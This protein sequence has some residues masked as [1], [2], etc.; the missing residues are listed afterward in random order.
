MKVLADRFTYKNRVFTIA[1]R[2]QDGIIVAIEDK[3]ID[4]NGRL[5]TALNGFNLLADRRANTVPEIIERI[6]ERVDYDEFMVDNAPQT[7]QEVLELTAYFFNCRQNAK[8]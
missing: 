7:Q 8:V 2:K 4:E 3:Y 5:T 1:E 6:Y